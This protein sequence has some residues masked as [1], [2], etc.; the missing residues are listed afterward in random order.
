MLGLLIGGGPPLGA[1]APSLVDAAEAARQ[2]WS[3][4]DVA[5][6]VG[7]S[8]RILLR[9]PRV[10][11]SGPVERAQ[12]AALLGDYLKGYEEVATEVRVVRE[13]GGGGGFVELRRR[14]RVVG[15][16]ELRSQ[17]VLLSYQLRGRAW[18]LGEVRISG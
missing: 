11:P 2:S 8:D 5:G 6:L 12:A 9:L 15:T 16:T 4:H 10:A 3:S 18:I 14:F 1:Q 17:A 7:T 13:L